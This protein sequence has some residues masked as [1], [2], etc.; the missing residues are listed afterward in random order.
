[1][2]T[3]PELTSRDRRRTLLGAG[4]GWTFDGYETYALILTLGA[5]LPALLPAEDHARIPFF[6]GAT[7]ALTLFGFGVGG[8]VG[9]V[10]ADRYG[11]RRTLLWTVCAYAALTG[12][13]ALAWD[14]WAFALLRLLTGVALGS[15]WSGHNTR[16]GDLAGP[17][18]VPRR[19]AHAK[20]CRG[21]VLR[22]RRHVVCSRPAQ[23][24]RMAVD[25]PDRN[26]PGR[27]R[28]RYPPPGTGVAGVGR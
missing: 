2:A 1:M 6:A 19:G 5:A 21:R 28:D 15:E 22:R 17:A 12:M 11:R 3:S 18:A 23:S 20:R 14:W 26:R 25:V 13:T 7:I 9:G 10:L 24:G 16:R 8:I 4:L 27:H